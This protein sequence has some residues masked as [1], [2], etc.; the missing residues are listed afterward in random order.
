[1]KVRTFLLLALLPFVFYGLKNEPWLG[2]VYE[3]E[4]LTNY[5]LS[6]FTSVDNAIVPLQ[7]TSWDHL[8]YA[9]LSFP[10][11]AS[12]SIDADVRFQATPR[13]DFGIQSIALQARHL[14]YDDIS[15]DPVSFVA[16]FN[17]RYTF[18]KS[19]KDISCPYHG[20]VDFEIN[21]SLGKEFNQGIHWHYRLWTLAGLGIAN[22]GS[23]WIYGLVAA[24][25]NQN[26]HYI[27]SLFL[28]GEEGFGK[29]HWVDIH[30]FKGYGKIDYGNIELTLRYGIR[31]H[32]WGTLRFDYIRRLLARSCPRNVNTFAITYVFPFSF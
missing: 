23:P 29:N 10:Y 30:H 28:S 14:F 3:L 26:D 32:Q 2:N 31:F 16:S 25:F 9:D 5:S 13:Q 27:F 6:F 8:L 12:G 4:L 7:K 15:G 24:E 21:A 1:M 11:S 18:D 19:L 22:E 20:D 17:A